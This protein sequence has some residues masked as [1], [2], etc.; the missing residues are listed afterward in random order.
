MEKTNKV[1]LIVITGVIVLYGALQFIMTFMILEPFYPVK[2]KFVMSFDQQYMYTQLN[3][4]KKTLCTV[5]ILEN[6]RF[7]EISY[8][9]PY[10][11]D[12]T[13]RMIEWG[14]TTND[15]FVYSSDIGLCIYRQTDDTWTVFSLKIV[16]DSN[17]TP[18]YHLSKYSTV[19]PEILPEIL[20]D[21]IP[22]GIKKIID[23]REKYYELEL[24]IELHKLVQ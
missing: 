14:L 18:I 17:D 9:L 13:I 19:Y 22:P 24:P 15:L 4:P 8:S 20:N 5:V 3:S 11:N 6:T 21:T 10:F 2:E 16:K 23:S 1:L 7:G 12:R